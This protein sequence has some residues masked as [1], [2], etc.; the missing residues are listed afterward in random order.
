M[1]VLKQKLGKLLKIMLK[2][3]LL[4]KGRMTHPLRRQMKTQ[5]WHFKGVYRTRIFAD[6]QGPSATKKLCL[7]ID[8]KLQLVF[9]GILTGRLLGI[10]GLIGLLGIFNYPLFKVYLF[11]YVE[12]MG[13][14]ILGTY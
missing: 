9:G 6:S 7:S 1:F 3:F 13:Q 5:P 12:Q 8:R 10:C 14:K 2:Y 4:L 11:D